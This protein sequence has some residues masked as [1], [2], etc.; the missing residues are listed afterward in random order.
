MRGYWRGALVAAL[1]LAGCSSAPVIPVN[2]N[3]T[4]VIE[5]AIL[6]A[7][8][9]ANAPDIDGDSADRTA[10][11]EIFNDTSQPVSVHY[12]F[13]W[14]DAEGLEMHPL[15]KTRMVSIPARGSVSVYSRQPFLGASLTRLYLSL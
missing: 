6:A 13:Y 15:E 14:Y 2:K 10:H 3:Q 11:S 1:F 9:T 12:R 5:P 8:I 4:L 7:G